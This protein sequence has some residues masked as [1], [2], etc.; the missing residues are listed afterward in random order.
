MLNA[1]FLVLK[2][3][4]TPVPSEYAVD[5][6]ESGVCAVETC[7]GMV[8]L[9]Q[10]ALPACATEGTW[11]DARGCMPPVDFSRSTAPALESDITL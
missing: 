9:P 6:C 3:A 1:V 11:V 5:Q 4:L 10:S 8:T 2:L 7:D